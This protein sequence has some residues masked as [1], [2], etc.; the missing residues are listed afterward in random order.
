MGSDARANKGHC[1]M[2]GGKLHERHLDA[3]SGIPGSRPGGDRRR[4][5]AEEE[6]EKTVSGEN[7]VEV[8]S[9]RCEHP[10]ST[11]SFFPS[12]ELQKKKGIEL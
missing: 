3:A 9:A 5:G 8:A 12:P 11:A 1:R 10:P 4:P 6:G 2:A 7:A